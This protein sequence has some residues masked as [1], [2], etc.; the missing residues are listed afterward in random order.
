MVYPMTFMMFY[1]VAERMHMDQ[2][3]VVL[4]FHRVTEIIW[5]SHSGS[6]D[7]V[8]YDFATNTV[9]GYT[10]E[11]IEPVKRN[12]VDVGS[13]VSVMVRAI[14]VNWLCVVV[15]RKTSEVE[16]DHRRY[17]RIVDDDAGETADVPADMVDHL[18]DRFAQKALC[19]KAS[20]HFFTADD[21]SVIGVASALL[22]KTV[23][24]LRSEFTSLVK[25][26]VD[27]LEVWQAATA[28]KEKAVERQT[29]LVSEA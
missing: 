1:N 26:L 13:V 9:Q 8:S 11:D 27:E 12:K 28:N 5:S 22:S 25:G 7:F 15:R 2:V 17:L 10:A 6:K 20:E 24:T 14:D 4:A 23:C 16:F 19:E 21:C 18:D 29:R 3:I